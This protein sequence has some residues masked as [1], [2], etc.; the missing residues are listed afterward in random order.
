MKISKKITLVTFLSIIL[1]ILLFI[2][3]NTLF[4]YK[5]YLHTRKLE[6]NSVVE[7]IVKNRYD[8]E[9]I[10]KLEKDLNIDIDIKNPIH[11][12][13]K[14]QRLMQPP[15]NFILNTN[16]PSLN[17][18]NF[19]KF[20][21]IEDF[22]IIDSDL[23]VN[24]IYKIK[25]NI[26]K[27]SISKIS[28]KQT[29]Q[30]TNKFIFIIGLFLSVIGFL[31]SLILSKLITRPILKLNNVVEKL[32]N[33]DFSEKLEIK[34]N[35]EIATLSKNVNFLS[36]KLEHNIDDLK[37]SNIKLQEVY[38]FEKKENQKRE[39]FIAALTHEIKTP[40]TIINTY[41][42]YL[43]SQDVDE[44][45]RRE[46][47][48]IVIQEGNDLSKILDKL[49]NYVKN[50]DNSIEKLNLKNFNYTELIEFRIKKFQLD[51]N[52]K[53]ITITKKIPKNIFIYADYDKMTYVLDNIL[54]NAVAH[55]YDNGDI[56]ITVFETKNTIVTEIYNSGSLINENNLEKIWD[57]FYKEDESRTR[58]YGGIGL[59]LA[60]VKKILLSHN[61]SFGAKN[62][63][64]GV[65]FW[66]SNIKQL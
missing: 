17:N 31:L 21:E 50:K 3:I 29:I 8:P 62:T 65:L 48:E 38:G 22:K 55:T 6:L 24:F 23:S 56:S 37:S 58:K 53:K 41:L 1:L 42:E 39:E 61:S 26:I 16:N 36:T 51:F 45:E 35:D 32:S 28:V 64:N 30:S 57:S 14:Q 33:L 2:I 15:D 52:E 5:F 47:S 43:N 19:G 27:I 9:V 66:F 20:D 44:S 10:N 63:N 40:I 13:M 4:S 49:I 46:F 7:E 12:N 11:N 54:S 18:R 59:G 34:G 25:E 60:F